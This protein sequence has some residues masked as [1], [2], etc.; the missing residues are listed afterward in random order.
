MQKPNLNHNLQVDFFEDT[1][2]YI[3]S[4]G[5]YL[6]GITGII[7]KML[8]PDKYNNI[9]KYILQRAADYGSLIHSKC[10]TQDMF[11]CNA[12]C[13]E[14]EN[15]IKIKNDNNLIPI[16]NEYLV[17]DNERIATMIDCV[18]GVSENTVD[19]GDIKTSSFLDTEYLSWQLSV[20]SWLFELQNPHIK[21]RNLYGIWL[22]KEESRFVTI[23]R[24]ENKEVS[25][26]INNYFEL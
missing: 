5:T 23:N 1:H 16:D 15:Y 14:V 12:D 8:F 18:Y 24:K 9:P 20:C 17:S 21:V 22:R 11:D 25:N 10:Q 2:S 19:I 7:S 3:R 4:D 13:T 6:I 26:L